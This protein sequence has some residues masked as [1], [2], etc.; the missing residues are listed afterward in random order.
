MAIDEADV[1]RHLYEAILGRSVAES[2][3][4][5][6]CAAL[7][8]GTATVSDVAEELRASAEAEQ[9]RR[10]Q[11]SG[12][13]REQRSELGEAV[14]RFL[15]AGVLGRPD[16]DEADIEPWVNS[17]R[18]SRL[19]LTE[20]IE[21]FLTSEEAIR[22]APR[23]PALGPLFGAP[24]RPS[25]RESPALV[26]AAGRPRLV[27]VGALA[28]D[29][30][31]DVWRPLADGGWTVVGFEPQDDEREARLAID[32][33]M[34]L[35][36]H[37]VGDGSPARFH[38]NE[39]PATSSLYP[40]ATATISRLHELEEGHRVAH[41]VD[42]ETTRL[43]DIADTA[44]AVFCKLDVQGA[45]LDVLRGAER[46]LAELLVIQAEVQ[47]NEMYAGA[48]FF[49]DVDGHLR[50]RGFELLD[51]IHQ[52]RYHHIDGRDRHPWRP[53]QFMWADAVWV[54]TPERLLAAPVES[55]VAAA[56]VVHELY[57]GY[58][59]ASRLLGQLD[60]LHGT[61][62]AAAHAG[63]VDIR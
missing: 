51:L 37:F 45:E 32:A 25:W 31:P 12:I 7:R 40:P 53:P 38:V 33:D 57:A 15:Y 60:R 9:H 48:P 27:D 29:D 47:F 50:P 19:T 1:V 56:W 46:R 24:T 5:P 62:L 23:T 30:E 26:A 55:A 44:G 10:S 63:L 20:V 16:V 58:D 11:R 35:H 54:A 22:A 41:V 36:P 52:T 42:V 14:V 28:L 4:P 34:I 6:W 39:V 13:E 21:S 18:D 2:E 17:I 59:W 61:D 3:L 49:A 8:D 43:D